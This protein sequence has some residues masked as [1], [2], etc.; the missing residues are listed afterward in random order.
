M[1]PFQFPTSTRQEGAGR[2]DQAQ[3]SILV[4]VPDNVIIHEVNPSPERAHLY[5]GFERV[6]CFLPP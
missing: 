4:E 2:T 6:P 1:V 3:S 5:W